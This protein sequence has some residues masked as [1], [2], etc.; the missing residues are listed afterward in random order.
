VT[1]LGVS[2][3]KNITLGRLSKFPKCLQLGR[4]VSPLAAVLGVPI[5]CAKDSRPIA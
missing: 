4:A 1:E 5:C 3:R 2:F